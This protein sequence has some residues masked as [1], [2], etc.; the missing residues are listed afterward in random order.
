MTPSDFLDSDRRRH[1]RIGVPSIMVSF[2]GQLYDT[3]SWSLGGFLVDRGRRSPIVLVRADL[4]E[5]LCDEL[6]ED[7]ELE[8]E[9]PDDDG[10]DD[11]EG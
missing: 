8:D 7:E 11:D 5:D 10:D 2:E 6:D 1:E 4:A 3:A 9:S